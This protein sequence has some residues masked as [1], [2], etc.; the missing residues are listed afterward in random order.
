MQLSGGIPYEVQVP[1]KF[2][3]S[4][5]PIKYYIYVM[6][7]D[8]LFTCYLIDDDSDDR[9]IFAIAVSELG[10][11]IQ[12]FT[13]VD[14]KAGLEQLSGGTFLP[15]MIFLDLNMPRMNGQQCLRMLK[16]DPAYA[17]I[18]VIIYSTSFQQRDREEMQL[19]GASGFVTKPSSIETLT[20][21]LTALFSGH[22]VTSRF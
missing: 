1:V 9:E 12:L 10:Y 11:P 15:D 3:V 16:A 13:A 7:P 21:I 2:G 6:N 17:S 19:L 8:K 5:S 20:E 22:A 18:P 14:G 4:G